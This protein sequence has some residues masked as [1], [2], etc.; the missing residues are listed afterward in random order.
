MLGEDYRFKE[1][2]RTSAGTTIENEFYKINIYE[3]INQ[4]KN[5]VLLHFMISPSSPTVI[6]FDIEIKDDGEKIEVTEVGIDSTLGLI[7]NWYDGRT[8]KI[9]VLKDLWVG[10]YDLRMPSEETIHFVERNV[11]EL[12][13]YLVKDFRH[14]SE[15]T[16]DAG[17]P[18]RYA[19]PE[20]L[21]TEMS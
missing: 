6:E 2:I 1:T 14:V 18:W 17:K 15:E 21:E 3:F 12:I 5:T 20:L 9:D 10:V 13:R 19:Y 7:Y 16:I 8:G 11:Y 4:K